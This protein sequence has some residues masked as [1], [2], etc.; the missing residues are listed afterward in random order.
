MPEDTKQSATQGPGTGASGRARVTKAAQA[1]REPESQPCKCQ[2]RRCFRCISPLS[3][4]A[5]GDQATAGKQ[6]RKHWALRG[7]QKVSRECGV[8]EGRDNAAGD[9]VGR[10]MGPRR[11]AK[12]ADKALGGEGEQGREQRQVARWPPGARSRGRESGE[13]CHLYCLKS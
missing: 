8:W 13:R 4:C 10:R 11:R 7:G 9:G 2:A 6:Q 12:A 3:Q 5:V 1:A